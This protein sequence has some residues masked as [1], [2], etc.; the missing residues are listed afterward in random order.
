MDCAESDASDS[1]EDDS[2]RA[3][4]WVFRAT[5]HGNL[6]GSSQF[7]TIKSLLDSRK[8]RQEECLAVAETITRTCSELSG[9]EPRTIS[10]KGF[11]RGHEKIGE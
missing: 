2:Q 7:S 6:V 4:T 10:V 11:V 3:Y 8:G 1:Q 5:V 9:T